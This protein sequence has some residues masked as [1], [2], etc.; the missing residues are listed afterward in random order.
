MALNILHI[1]VF[2]S[3]GSYAYR[4]QVYKQICKFYKTQKITKYTVITQ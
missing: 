2:T 4:A 3:L 1:P